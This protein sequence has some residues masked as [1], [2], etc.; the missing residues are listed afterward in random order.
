MKTIWKFLLA[1]PDPLQNVHAPVGA[2]PLSLHVIA[3]KVWLFLEVDPN[4]HVRRYAVRTVVT[5]HGVPDDAGVY[6]GTYVLT[7]EESLIDKMTIGHV[8]LLEYPN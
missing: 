8:Y 5:G 3:G 7:A 1:A 4:A 6:V 2:V